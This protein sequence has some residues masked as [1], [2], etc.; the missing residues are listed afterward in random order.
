MRD[1]TRAFGTFTDTI[2]AVF[3]ALLLAGTPVVAQDGDN[4]SVPSTEEVLLAL[5]E[6]NL[7]L[8]GLQVRSALAAGDPGGSA[9]LQLPDGTLVD[10]R[11]VKTIRG[12]SVRSF[13]FVA[14]DGAHFEGWTNPWRRRV[15]A[16]ER[17]LA[18]AE[19]IPIEALE[20]RAQE[21]A[22]L[23]W[24][25]DPD[26][27]TRLWGLNPVTFRMMQALKMVPMGPMDGSAGFAN[28]VP[29]QP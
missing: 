21:L 16:A 20:R 24:F 1:D 18:S 19:Q 14:G 3:L 6:V 10:V 4:S 17:F 5:R 13:Y 25:E 2:T 11:L 8:D 7:S 22:P 15:E 23:V 29:R 28:P 27:S 12:W 26:E 9:L